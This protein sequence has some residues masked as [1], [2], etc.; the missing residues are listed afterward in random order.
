MKELKR[1]RKYTAEIPIAVCSGNQNSGDH[2]SLTDTELDKISEKIGFK[3][4]KIHAG[5]KEHLIQVNDHENIYTAPSENF[6]L[7]NFTQN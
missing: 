6:D 5:D 1:L 7:P 3:N 2:L 4:I